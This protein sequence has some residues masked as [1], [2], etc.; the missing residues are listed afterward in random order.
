VHFSAYA[1]AN[2]VPDDAIP[3][4][5]EGGLD[6]SRNVPYPISG[7]DGGDARVKGFFGLNTEGLSFGANLTD[8]DGSSIVTDKSIAAND[9]V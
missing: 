1:V 3:P 5:A 4:W 6:G 8:G 7:S 2:E 9:D